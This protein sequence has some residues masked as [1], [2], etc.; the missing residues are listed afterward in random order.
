MR[1]VLAGCMGILLITSV[2]AEA[3]NASRRTKSTI[4][5]GVSAYC[6]LTGTGTLSAR[7]SNASSFDMKC[8]VNCFYRQP[9]GGIESF[10]CATTIPAGTLDRTICPKT[11]KANLI[12]KQVSSCKKASLG[13]LGAFAT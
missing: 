10:G 5:P 4:P 1:F 11:V 13:S 2:T 7:G 8:K 6:N 12:K 3:Q 9:A